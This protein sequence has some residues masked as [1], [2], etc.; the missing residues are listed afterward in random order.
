MRGVAY[1]N[2]Y[3]T[4]K[5]RRRPFTDEDEEIVIAARGAGRGRD[6]ERAPLRVGDALV[7]PARDA[8]RDR[9]LDRRGDGARPAARSSS[10]AG[11]RADGARIAF[12]ALAEPR[13]RPRDRRLRRRGRRG[14]RRCSGIASAGTRQRWVACFERRQSARIDSLLDD[15][16]VAQEEARAIG[17]ATGLY[18]PLVARG[19]ALGVIA[20]HDKL[21]GD[22]RFSDADL[23]L[24]EIFA[25]RAAVAVGAVASA[26]RATPS[27]ASSTAQEAERRRLALELHDETGQAL[28]SILLGAEGDPV[29]SGRRARRSGPKRMSRASSSRRSR[30]CAR[31]PSSSGRRRS[32][33]SGS[34]R[35]SSGSAQTF[36]E[37]SGIETSMRGATSRSACR[38]RSRRRSTASSQEALT[39][40]VK[41]AGAE[42]VSIV[43]SQARRKGGCDDR[44]RRPRLRE[45]RGARR[46]A[47]PA[48]DA[49][50]ARARRRD[51]QRRVDRRDRGRRSPLRCRCTGEA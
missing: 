27:G 51:A 1:G 6:R 28:T 30:T 42:H 22:A 39:N 23:R 16:E 13:R 47:R 38:P 12:A 31:S 49:R 9:A 40:V 18:V 24:V 35:R 7:A 50:A 26:S 10:A 41:H 32:T 21:G 36:S 33:T 2:L 48:R 15:P 8:A 44:R 3:L 29:G 11:A 25:A 4:E 20:V 14:P 37:R 34:G 45:R 5:T 17:A 43:V 46:R 19:S